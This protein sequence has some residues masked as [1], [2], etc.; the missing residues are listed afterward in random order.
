[1]TQPRP[2]PDFRRVDLELATIRR[3]SLFGHIYP[4]GFPNPLGCGKTPSRFSDPRRRIAKNRFGVL[5]LGS[6]LTVCFLEA[7]LRDLRNGAISDYPIEEAELHARNYAVIAVGDPL[8]L[9]DL[10]GNGPVKMG[11]PS[12]VIGASRQSLS[13]ARSLALHEHPERPD[14]MSTPH[15]SMAKRTSPLFVFRLP[16]L[17]S[18]RRVSPE[19]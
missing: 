19:F 8:H 11:I 16:A 4:N 17:S 1:M 14:G 15:G 3:G 6:S 12:D 5:Y 7:I 13:R 18:L 9:V 10:R 2:T